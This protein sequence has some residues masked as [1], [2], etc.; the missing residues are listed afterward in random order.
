MELFKRMATN[1]QSLKQFNPFSRRR[2]ST[3]CG[4]GLVLLMWGIAAGP[5]AAQKKYTP[6]SLEVEEIVNRSIRFLQGNQPSGLGEKALSALAIVEAR[7]R[8]DQGNLTEDSLVRSAIAD[9][10]SH[11]P[12]EVPAGVDE[13]HLLTM[14]EVYIPAMSLILLAEVDKTRYRS[15]INRLVA[16][17]EKRFQPH[18]ALTYSNRDQSVGD[19]S[20][21][22]YAA[23]ALYVANHHGFKIDAEIARRALE[24]LCDSQQATGNFHYHLMRNN[25]RWQ[26]DSLSMRS[27]LAI[28]VGGLGTV[29]LLADMLRL[30]PRKKRMAKVATGETFVDL[31]KTVMEYVPT[32]D[33]D[34][35][36][37]FS[38]D[39]PV[40]RFDLSKLAT[41]TGAGNRSLQSRFELDIEQWNFYYLYAL[42]RYAWFREQAEGNISGGDL[43]NWYDL[44]VEFLKEKQQASGGFFKLNFTPESQAVCTAFAIL[45]LVRSSE[46]ISSPPRESDLVGD[47]GFPSGTLSVDGT[48]VI[49]GDAEKD[50]TAL[51]S[52]LKEKPTEEQLEAI[53][54]SM[55]R[56]I[57][58]F[59]TMEDKSRGEIK[60]FLRTMVTSDNFYRRKIAVRFL[61]SEQDMDNVPAL[62]YLLGDPEFE[63]CLEAHDGLRLIS[64]RID[65]MPLSESTRRKS[66]DFYLIDASGNDAEIMRSEYDSLKKQ[67]TEWFLKIRPD[68]DLLD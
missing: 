34:S 51:M 54:L 43:P 44:G 25:N 61:A 10:L 33:G 64:R 60:A 62:L 30:Y 63:I 41:S 3:A 16:S 48:N 29:Y 7:K 56:A 31:P 39:G 15:E 6:D 37:P 13:R 35:S 58:D 26:P 24:W 52:M 45:F 40:V 53:A 46:I 59:A 18:G 50:I 14:N 9:V 65:T 11:L 55:K 20:Q 67:W 28:H 57:E 66:E 4:L 42:E 49:G 12:A 36:N 2:I 38:G 47:I 17:I 1:R 32:A 5:L 68:A 21:V 8:Y 23:L 22:Q 27:G 19:T